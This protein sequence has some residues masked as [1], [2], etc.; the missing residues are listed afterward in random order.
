[1]APVTWRPF[2]RRGLL[3]T[4]LHLALA[5]LFAGPPVLADSQR[6]SGTI[7]VDGRRRTYVLSR[8]NDLATAARPTP[9]VIALHG[10]RGTAERLIDYFGLDPIAARE[11]FAVVYPQGLDNMWSDGRARPGGPDDVAFLKALADDL[12]RRGI[13][14]PRRIYVTGLSNGGGMALRLACEASDRFAAFAPMIVPAPVAMR[15]TCRP[16]RPIP[17]LLINGTADKLVPY[18]GA[19]SRRWDDRPMMAAVDHARFWAEHN[20]CGAPTSEALPDLDPQD[21]STARRQTWTGCRDGGAVEHIIIEGGGHQP[22]RIGPSRGELITGVFL[23]NRNRDIDA[24]L[25]AWQFFRRF[26]R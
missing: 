15:Q 19:A 9:L 20:R 21:G 4:A 18:A 13:A 10:G 11:G 23:G 17:I 6:T 25:A 5:V 3:A 7:A 12:V 1:M 26:A 2:R 8:S 14:D 16:P 22:P 24:A